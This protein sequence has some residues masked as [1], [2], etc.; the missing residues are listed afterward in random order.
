MPN[1]QPVKKP[2]AAIIRTGS[3]FI[4]VFDSGVG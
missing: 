4:I 2:I 1:I 3:F